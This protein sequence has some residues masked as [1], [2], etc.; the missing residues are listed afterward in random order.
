[1]DGVSL[2]ADYHEPGMDFVGEWDNGDDNFY[3]GVI[4]LVK[5]GAMADDETLARLVEDYGIEEDLEFYADEET[6]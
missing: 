3:D 2:V 4:D 6:A 5:G 1:M